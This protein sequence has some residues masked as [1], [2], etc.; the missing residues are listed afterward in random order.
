MRHNLEH[1]D[2]NSLALPVGI[3]LVLRFVNVLQP[4][5]NANFQENTLLKEYVCVESLVMH[6][7]QSVCILS[8]VLLQL[9][10]FPL[11]SHI[12]AHP[13]TRRPV[14]DS[15]ER[16]LSCACRFCGGSNERTERGKYIKR[17]GI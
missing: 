14:T 4:Q 10:V 13:N 12:I 3:I 16:V 1:S 8:I 17:Y 11:C 2:Y 15:S 7:W 5:R 6:V 9:H